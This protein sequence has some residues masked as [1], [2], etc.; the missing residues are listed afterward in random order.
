[1]RVGMSA[2]LGGLVE[3]RSRIDHE[4]DRNDRQKRQEKV[5]KSRSYYARSNGSERRDRQR[6]A[7]K[8]SDCQDNGVGNAAWRGKRTAKCQAHGHPNEN[9]GG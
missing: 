9:R 2:A 6:S 8:K 4:A 7:G 3:A 1:M 5:A